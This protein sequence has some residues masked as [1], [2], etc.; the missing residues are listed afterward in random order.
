[1]KLKKNQLKKVPRTRNLSQLELT[2]QAHNKG[3]VTE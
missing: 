1:M 3:H 2:C